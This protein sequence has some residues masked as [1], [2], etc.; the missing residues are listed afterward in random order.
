MHVHLDAPDL[1]PENPTNPRLK[2][3]AHTEFQLLNNKQFRR[4]DSKFLNPRYVV[5]ESE[6]FDTIANEHLQH[7]HTGYIKIWAAIQQKYY[8]I[9]R[10]EVAFVLK[11]F[12][13]CALNRPATTKA[14]LIP[15]I[16]GRAWERVQID[17]IDMRHEPSG[18]FKWILHIKDRF[19]KYTQLYPLKSKH[20]EAVA[21]SSAQFVA[22]FLPP[23]IMQSD[24][25]KELKGVETNSEL[26]KW[27]TDQPSKLTG[28]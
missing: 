15:I 19:S 18:Q 3:R 23:K 13:N 22:A 4:P 10:Q 28:Y 21:D 24:N 6:A 8:G 17:L 11:L 27:I 2:H 16:S 14:P 26:G 5:P 9:T 25:G 7:L 1:K 12:K 20:A